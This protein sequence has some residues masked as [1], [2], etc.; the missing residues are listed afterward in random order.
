MH[1]W[2][3]VQAL[4]TL[5]TF[6]SKY[7]AE[8]YLEWQADKNAATIPVRHT[9]SIVTERSKFEVCP[10]PASKISALSNELLKF[11]Y[12]NNKTS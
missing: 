7:N 5:V 8:F 2:M 4:V 10:L 9:G 3:Q 12:T 6:A 11:P 1:T